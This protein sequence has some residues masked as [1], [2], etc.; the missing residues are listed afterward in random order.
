M[1]LGTGCAGGSNFGA[2]IAIIVVI[3][4]LLIALGIVF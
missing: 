3:I 2:G 1:A 4:L